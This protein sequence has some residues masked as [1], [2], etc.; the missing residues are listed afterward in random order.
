MYVNAKMI[1]IETFLG[2]RG[3]EGWERAVE[4]QSM[5]YLLH[6]KNLCKCY[7]VLPP[8]T[9]IKKNVAYN[10]KKKHTHRHT[11]THAKPVWIDSYYNLCM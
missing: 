8:S 6:C 10:K 9:T 7:N 11:H 2:V 3:W 1:P 5:L 4:G